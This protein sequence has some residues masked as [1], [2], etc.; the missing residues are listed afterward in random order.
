M[1]TQ[2]SDQRVRVALN[3]ARTKKRKRKNI[4]Q[5]RDERREQKKE[6]KKKKKEEAMIGLG[7]T[8]H[9]ACFVFGETKIS[10]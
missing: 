5:Q 10:Q 3:F 9:C 8:G 6:K 4:N 2:D 7:L 1:E